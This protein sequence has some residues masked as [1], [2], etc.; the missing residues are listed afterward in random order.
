MTDLP[1]VTVIIPSYNHAQYIENAIQSVLDQTYQN[2]ELIV[3]DDG[4]QDQSHAVIS[5]FSNHPKITTILNKQNKGQ[6]SVL[7]QAIRLAKGKYISLLPSDDWYLPHKTAVQ[8]AKFET[9]GDEV[10]A[11]YAAGARFFEDTGETQN[12]KWRVPCHGNSC[13]FWLQHH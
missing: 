6:S 10:G 12:V 5:K 1:L 8:V 2:L 9:C 11:V 4:S 3:V 7:N 13:C